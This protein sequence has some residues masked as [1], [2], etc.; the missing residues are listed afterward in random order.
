MTTLKYWLLLLIGFLLV[1]FSIIYGLRIWYLERDVPLRGIDEWV[2]EHQLSKVLLVFAH[3]DD[4]LLVAGTIAGLNEN[5]V[6]TYLLTLTNGDGESRPDGQSIEDLV[7]ERTAELE[8]VGAV[9]GI[10]DVSQG[11][12]SD[13]GFMDVADEPIKAAIRRHIDRFQPDAIIT[14]DTE[15]GLYGHRHHVRVAELTIEVAEGYLSQ[16][17]TISVFS[18]TVAVWIREALKELS[19]LYQRRYYEISPGESI[20]PAFA[21]ATGNFADLR[22]SAFAVYHKRGAVGALNPLAEFPTQI[23]DFVFD[24]EY[25]YR[26]F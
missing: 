26:S 11:L 15:K 6:D 22:R 5:G 13:L 14:W 20:E 3:Q 19:P 9:L 21:L 23:E 12:F 10:D 25:F 4:E 16:G 1:L 18:S 7:K 8:S 24:R 17:R 2:E